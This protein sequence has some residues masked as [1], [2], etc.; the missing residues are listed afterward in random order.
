MTGGRKFVLVE[1][2]LKNEVGTC[3][4]CIPH[5]PGHIFLGLMIRRK[6]IRELC[7]CIARRL[8]DEKDIPVG[9][10]MVGV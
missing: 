4:M 5:V 3:Y 1:A 6:S 7:F 2:S 9:S 10:I 8:V